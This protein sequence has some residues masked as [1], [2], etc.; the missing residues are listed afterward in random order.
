[1]KDGKTL[2]K[3]N[4]N[5]LGIE[6]TCCRICKLNNHLYLNTIYKINK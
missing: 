6:H 5:N 1:M 2:I 3:N 4:N